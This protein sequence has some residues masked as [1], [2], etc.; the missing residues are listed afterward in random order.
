MRGVT[1]RIL[2]SSLLLRAPGHH[3]S[4][5]CTCTKTRADLALVER[6]ILDLEEAVRHGDRAAL[7]ELHALQVLRDR[8]EARLL[9]V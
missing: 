9:A 1:Q 4:M 3:S 2:S 7:A 5:P 6:E 8:I